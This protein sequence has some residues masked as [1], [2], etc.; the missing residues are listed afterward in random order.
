MSDIITSVGSKL[1]KISLIIFT[2][3]KQKLI[4]CFQC[5]GV[6]VELAA[7]S[8]NVQALPESIREEVLLGDRP[9]G[10]ILLQ[11][12]VPQQCHPRGFFRLSALRVLNEQFKM[13]ENEP[14]FGRWN[15]IVAPDGTQIAS[16]VEIIPGSRRCADIQVQIS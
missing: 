15:E 14:T 13:D 4:A 9:F 2:K 10:A 16:V 11:A 3:S 7:I 12:Q 1:F 5:G 6:S 8:I